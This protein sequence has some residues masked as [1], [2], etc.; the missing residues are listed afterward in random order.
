LTCCRDWSI[1]VDEDALAD[2]RNAPDGLR[3]EILKNLVTDEDGDVCFRLR[4]DGA[5]ALLDGD[6]L[7]PI[8]RHWGQAHLCTHCGAYPRFIEEY[9]CLTE[10]CTAISCPEGARLVLEQGVLPLRQ[11]D[12]GGDEPAFDGVDG[13]L[14]DGLVVSREKAFR[15]MGDRSQSIW[16]RLAALL[17]YADQLQDCV[18]KGATL[19]NVQ[20]PE[21]KLNESSGDM[22][23]LTVRLLELLAGL[24]PLRGSWPA[25]LHRRASELGSLGRQ[26][27]ALMTA[28][29]QAAWPDWEA[30]LER[31]ADYFLFRHWPKVV[32]DDRLYGRAA[33]TAAGCVVLFHLAVLGWNEDKGFDL[34][35]LSL[36][37]AAF[38][39]EVEHL[40]ENFDALV[41]TLGDRESWPLAQWL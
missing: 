6:G 33:F 3:E 17:D 7:C 8:Q 35:T 4:E 28:G 20:P 23:A 26:E 14:L 1:V 38:S 12:D 21:P 24:E 11:W 34:G 15:L 16:R 40:D 25:L 13:A 27:Y 31:L 5:C 19:E 10:A 39:R 9:G 22:R 29:F 41:D 32:N 37:W 36:L 2:Y 30:Q 18:Y